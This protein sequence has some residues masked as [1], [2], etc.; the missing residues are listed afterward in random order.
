[1]KKLILIILIAVGLQVSAQ[2]VDVDFIKQYTLTTYTMDGDTSYVFK[3][4][5]QY[6]FDIQFVWAS[7]DQTDGSVKVQISEDGTNYEDYP[8]TDS[9]LFNSAG[10]SG[11]I[12]DTYKGTASRYIKLNVDS[13]T[14]SAGTLDIFG[15]LAKKK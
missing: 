4:T 10:G 5:A 9:L 11:I 15:N 3:T 7:L 13:G 6:Y 12:R 8:N 2:Q 14:C 1:M